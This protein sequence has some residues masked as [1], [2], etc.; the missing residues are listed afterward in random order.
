MCKLQGFQ[1]KC[2]IDMPICCATSVASRLVQYKVWSGAGDLVHGRAAHLAMTKPSQSIDRSTCLPCKGLESF[3]LPQ[4]DHSPHSS[5][6]TSEDIVPSRNHHISII[7]NENCQKRGVGSKYVKHL[8]PSIICAIVAV[9]PFGPSA[10]M[11]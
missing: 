5:S 4:T 6:Y 11:V 1:D 10:L 9:K 7:I 2:Y 3:V 8:G